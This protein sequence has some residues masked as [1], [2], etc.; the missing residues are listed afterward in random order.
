MPAVTGLGHVGFFVS[1]FERSLAF[2]QRLGFRVV[3]DL[4]EGGN[5]AFERGL[6]MQNP[7]DARRC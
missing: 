3:R 6:Q 2:Y 4:G 5:K 7:V 1:N